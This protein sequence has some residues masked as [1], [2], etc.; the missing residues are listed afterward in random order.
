MTGLLV[1][2][3][4]SH[5]LFEMFQLGPLLHDLLRCANPDDA[6]LTLNLRSILLNLNLLTH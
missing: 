2:C 6:F 3:R 1:V 5:K 4:A